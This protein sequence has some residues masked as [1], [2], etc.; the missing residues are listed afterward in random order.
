MTDTL[1]GTRLDAAMQ[2]VWEL[3][4]QRGEP[5]PVDDP[6]GAYWRALAERSGLAHRLVW[7]IPDDAMSE[8]WRTDTDDGQDVTRDLDARLGVE[9]ATR[10]A[11]GCAR[12]DGGAWLWPVIDAADWRTPLGEGSHQIQALHV[13]TRPEVEPIAWDPDPRSPTWGAPVLWQVT[14]SR[15]AGRWSGSVIHRSRLIYLPGAETPPTV[16]GLSDGYDLSVLAG[17]APAIREIERAWRATGDAMQ[18]RATPWV[19]LKGIGAALA[20]AQGDGSTVMGAITSRL[21][22]IASGVRNGGMVTLLGDDEMGWS[23]PPLAGTSETIRSLALWLSAREGIP[24]TRILGE[25]TSGL[26]SADEPGAAAYRDLLSRERRRVPEPAML[27]LYE[28]AMGPDLSRRIVWP[29]PVTPTAQERAQ[30]SLTLMQRDALAVTSGILTAGEV[31]GRF[32]DGEET[33]LPVLDD[34]PM[35]PPSEADGALLEYDGQ[36]ADASSPGRPARLPLAALSAYRDGLRRHE[37]G[38]TGDGI[39]PITIRMARAFVRG[40]RPTP[41]WIEKGRDWW[42]RNERFLDEPKGSP[43]YASAQLWG[44]RGGLSYYPSEAKRLAG[45][46]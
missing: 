40:E 27:R 32:E 46:E 42:A 17:Y 12:M 21:T 43:A 44:G 16:D 28:L 33:E 38:E 7:S 26:S 36:R 37:A 23:A 14:P 4:G 25:Q 30:T 13:L 1:S 18:R 8:G 2:V 45:G 10:E 6:S 3:V 39:E 41:E 9:D 5:V 22:A 20:G 11:W 29:D 31:R 19:R 24:L 35:P 34:T 15:G